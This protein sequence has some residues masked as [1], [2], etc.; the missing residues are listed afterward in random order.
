MCIVRVFFLT[1][2]KRKRFLSLFS[3]SLSVSQN[4]QKVLCWLTAAAVLQA[5][6][7]RKE[8]AEERKRQEGRRKQRGGGGHVAALRLDV[9]VQVTSQAQ[10]GYSTI[11]YRNP[12]PIYAHVLATICWYSFRRG[13]GISGIQWRTRTPPTLPMVAARRL[14]KSTR[15]GPH[16]FA[17]WLA[18]RSFA[19]CAALAEVSSSILRASVTTFDG[20]L[21]SSFTSSPFHPLLISQLLF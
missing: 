17:A 15:P 11:P 3:P 10:A 4:K 1:Q 21:G 5:A 16:G 12:A 9:G 20:S 2:Q 7:A 14:P 8:A 18:T 6:P 19:R 13:T